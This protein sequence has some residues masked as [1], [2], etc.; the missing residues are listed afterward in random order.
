LKILYYNISLKN[1]PLFD[2]SPFLGM[3]I[4][5]AE[6]RLGN[7]QPDKMYSL[8]LIECGGWTDLAESQGDSLL[9]GYHFRPSPSRWTVPLQS[10]ECEMTEFS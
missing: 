3:I 7:V 10:L 5:Q 8:Y 1:L 9:N 2:K 4:S 6:I